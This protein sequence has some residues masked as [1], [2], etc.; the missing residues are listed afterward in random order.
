MQVVSRLDLF[1]IEIQEVS[2]CVGPR[3]QCLWES[4][5]IC[6]EAERRREAKGVDQG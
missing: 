2:G 1:L 4:C 5:G 3:A 6:C